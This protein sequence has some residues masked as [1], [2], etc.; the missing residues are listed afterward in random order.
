MSANEAALKPARPKTPRKAALSFIIAVVVIDMLGIGLTWPILPQLVKDLTGKEVGEAAVIYGLLMS[1]YALV[2]FFVSPLMGMLSD[3]FGRRP[4]LLVSLT[5]LGLNY[6]LLALAPSLWLIVVGRL[7][8]GA[9]GATISTANAYIADVTPREKRAAAFGLI[10]AAFGVGFVVGP[11]LGGTLGEIDLRLPFWVAAGLS[12][13]AVTFGA[14]VLPESLPPE[15]RQPVAWVKANP[16]KA[17]GYVS[18]YPVLTSLMVVY[19]TA[20][21]AQQGLQGI[22]V[23]WTEAQFDFGVAEAGYSLAWVGLCSAF[24]QGYLVRII[25]PKFGEWRVVIGGYAISMI[26]FI[27]LPFLTASW[28]LYPGILFHILGWGSA[29]PALQSLM[30]QT[31]PDNEQGLL[32]GTLA[33][34]N[35]VG[36]V[37]GPV[38]ATQV[39]AVSTGSDAIIAFPGAYFWMGAVLFGIALL[40]M[41][42][43]RNSL[44]AASD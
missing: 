3:R 42:R 18:R 9:L 41:A 32:Q 40:I 14:L 17:F 36:L 43:Q 1:G 13:V 15:K 16:F 4:I 28:M 27:G 23:L 2:Q 22:W 21:L 31:V 19:L 5:G 39:F 34:V 25:V 35:T 20:G 8:A 7:F 26:A 12:F 30:S 44:A 24:V 33:S 38:V 37:I 10:G 11:L 29:G 6:I